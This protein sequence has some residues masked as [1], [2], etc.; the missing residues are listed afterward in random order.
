M[1]AR[2][3]PPTANSTWSETTNNAPTQFGP[4]TVA[5]PDSFAPAEAPA[6]GTA[7][8][9]VNPPPANLPPPGGALPAQPLY[10][11]VPVESAHKG[12][13]KTL[14]LAI[15][16]AVLL[17]AVIS[18]GLLFARSFNKA[19]AGAANSPQATSA[20]A[21]S[22]TASPTPT[23]I[24][25]SA[26]R[27]PNGLFSIHYPGSWAQAGFSP[28]GVPFPLPLNGVRFSSGQAD[29]VILTGQ[30]PPLMPTNGLAAQADDTLLGTMNAQQVS[31]PRPVKIGGQTWTE[32][33]ANTSG[34]KHTIIASI[35]F[36]QHIY[37]LWYSAPASEFSADEQ[38]VF[39]PMVA[40]FSFGG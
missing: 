6:R 27:D 24:P 39:N 10:R 9:G 28:R 31:A 5:P 34:G 23:P 14:A 13:G 2:L 29:F 7:P 12:R 22:P 30:E 32:K 8:F 11:S 25:T 36:N 26:Y 3:D 4:F 37:S 19:P 18:G 1:L 38:Q 16:A 17:L 40:N 21:P 33:S 20:A 35:S 15:V